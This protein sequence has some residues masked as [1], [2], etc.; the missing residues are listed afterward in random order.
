MADKI[1]SDIYSQLGL[2]KTQTPKT[3]KNDNLG[4]D[5]FLEL[6]TAQL[7][8]QDPLKPMENG[9]FIA[10]MAQFGT[11]SGIGDLNTA[12]SNMSAAFQSNQ[13]LQ[14][15]T[16]V[17]RSVLLESDTVGFDKAGLLNGSVELDQSA[18][19]VVV[20][21]S[22]QSGQIVNRQDLGFQSAGLV[23]FNWDG[24]L[25][26]GTK[27]TDGTYKVSAEVVR[28]DD[29]SSGVTLTSSLVESVTLGKG[30]QD[31]TLTVS[32]LGDISMSQIRKIM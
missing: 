6:M 10:Q 1:N 19:K 26:D 17:G 14:A 9:D 7:K 25:E 23:D 31:L 4:Q 16:M 27:L 3:N 5:E 18:S 29:V 20:T 24:T 13:A 32:N 8:F 12:F 22:D 15:S 21:I 11:V 2:N 28:G 30:G